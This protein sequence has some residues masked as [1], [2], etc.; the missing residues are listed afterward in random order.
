LPDGFRFDFGPGGAAPGFLRVSPATVYE[1]SRGYGV[2]PG[3]VVEGVDRGGGDPLRGDFCTS[4]APFSFSVAVPEGNYRVTVTLGDRDGASVTT[5]KAESRRLMLERVRTEPGVFATR[6]FTVNVRSPAIASG[7]RVRLKDR[8][9]GVPDWDDR[10]TLE[11]GDTRPCVGSVEVA[12]ADDAVTLFLVG[13][14]TV[15][16]QPREPWN[17]WGQMLP[18]FFG[19]GVAVA[20]HAESGETLKSSLASRRLDKVLSVMRPGD[21]LLVQFGHNDQKERGPG[22]GAATTYKADLKRYAAEARRRGGTPVLVTPVNRRTFDADG[23]VV[24]SLGGYPDAVR[25][26]A[27]E[28]GAALI[29]LNAASK[30]LYEAWGPG[31]AA[32]AFVDGTHHNAY[33]S[34]ELARCVVEGIRRGV[35]GL[36]RH[37]ADD[38]PPFD[39]ARPDPPE[40]F[41]VPASPGRSDAAP[42][43]R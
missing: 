7:G 39:P 36:A 20:N 30:A 3:S 35:P 6:T 26:A 32:K 13:D 4:E 33:G 29:D 16:D 19:P 43:G 25:E 38:A 12:R 31:V 14:S 5:V 1:A 10:L 22:V 9:R 2:E 18:R 37:L 8:E 23:R 21:Y 28:D 24:N 15:T 17:S 40:G 34:Y 42:D 11:F 41:R 27:R